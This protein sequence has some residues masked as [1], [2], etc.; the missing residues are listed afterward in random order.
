MKLVVDSNVLISAIFWYGSPHRL[1]AHARGGEPRLVTSPALLAELAEVLE[2][3]EFQKMARRLGLTSP[4]ILADLQLVSEVVHPQPLGERVCRDPD[5][6]DV[7]ACAVSARADLIVS[8]DKDLLSLGSFGGIAIMSPA[9]A[10]EHLGL[11]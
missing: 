8:G 5:D 7:L 1:L 2:R 11:E 6:D 4:A 3:P 10:L 9:T